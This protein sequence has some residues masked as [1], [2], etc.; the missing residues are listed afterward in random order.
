MVLGP[1]G[2]GKSTQAEN[3]ARLLAVPHVSTGNLLRREVAEGTPLGRRVAPLLAKGELLADD[4][5]VEIVLARLGEMGRSGFVLDGF[6]RTQAQAEALERWERSTGLALDAVV[7][8]EVA[9]PE[10]VRRLTERGRSQDRPDDTSETVRRR[11]ELDAELTSPLKD[12]YR[13]R[14]ILLDIDGSL[15]EPDVTELILERLRGARRS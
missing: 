5:I 15:P 1:P 7:W 6:P 8:L 12:F 3:L 9:R 13:A 10:L 2:A 14:G 4:L 11:L